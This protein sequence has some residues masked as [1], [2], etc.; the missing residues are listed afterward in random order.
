MFSLFYTSMQ[1]KFR[2]L[3]IRP[4]NVNNSSVTEEGFDPVFHS[5]PPTTQKIYQSQAYMRYIEGLTV[6]SDSM[7]DW[8]TELSSSA[9]I[10]LGYNSDDP[11]SDPLHISPWLQRLSNKD[12]HTSVDTIFA[13]RDFMLQEALNVVKVA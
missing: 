4:Q 8:Q 9:D 10:F 7:C 1:Y 2:L 5:V 11:D 13:L 12:S 6:D 3:N